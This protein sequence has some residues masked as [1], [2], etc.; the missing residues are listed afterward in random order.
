[1]TTGADGM[2]MPSGKSKP[3]TTTRIWI[4]SRAQSLT[5]VFA[6]TWSFPEVLMRAS[7]EAVM[8]PPR[9]LS[10]RRIGAIVRWSH[11]TA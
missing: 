4:R 5:G 2:N 11:R 7:T 9:M 3:L 6:R 10:R 1:M 8:E